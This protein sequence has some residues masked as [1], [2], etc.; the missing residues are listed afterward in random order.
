MYLVLPGTHTPSVLDQGIEKLDLEE[1]AGFA[2][3]APLLS[4]KYWYLKPRPTLQASNAFSLPLA[5]LPGTAKTSLRSSAAAQVSNPWPHPFVVVRPETQRASLPACKKPDSC[6]QAASYHGLPLICQQ[7]C[8]A[9][10]SSSAR[11]V[12]GGT[13]M[14]A[15][16]A[17]DCPCTIIG[18]GRIGTAV[19]PIS[20]ILF[21]TPSHCAH[22]H[23][24]DDAWLSRRCGPHPSHRICP[25]LRMSLPD[26]F[27]KLSVYKMAR[28]PSVI[29]CLDTH[30][31][32]VHVL[33]R[34]SSYMRARAH[35]CMQRR[36]QAV[37]CRHT[38]LRLRDPQSAC[39]L[40]VCAVGRH[41]KGRRVR[42]HDRQEGRANPCR[43][44]LSLHCVMQHGVPLSTH[45]RIV[46][47]K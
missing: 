42:R 8:F 40:P 23:Y 9:P 41:G 6:A 37:P 15:A 21:C 5:T 14:A 7:H 24:R 3:D 43:R 36:V 47:S 10:R 20:Y 22:Q 34:F 13:R 31:Y 18:A 16:P 28:I 4:T 1:E 29:T 19:R 30:T 25:Y 17:S 46:S 38:R 27:A 35:V 45:I 32:Y 12:L 39:K 2:E 33:V 26:S 44:W 11:S